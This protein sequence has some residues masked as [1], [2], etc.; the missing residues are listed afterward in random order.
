[1]QQECQEAVSRGIPG[2]RLQLPI[3][4]RNCLSETA[5]VVKAAGAKQQGVRK[6]LYDGLC[7][8]LLQ[9]LRVTRLHEQCERQA[10]MP[11]VSLRLATQRS[12]QVPLCVAVPSCL[13]VSTP[14][15]REQAAFSR[16]QLQTGVD[17]APCGIPLLRFESF[18]DRILAK[19]EIAGIGRNV[20]QEACQPLGC[21]CCWVYHGPGRTK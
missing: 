15:E 9:C 10:E 6:C 11:L 13:Q 3:A 5:K 1:M 8:E 20:G 12:G 4:L 21:R 19:R 2:R 7:A 16:M 17:Q 14:R 18:A